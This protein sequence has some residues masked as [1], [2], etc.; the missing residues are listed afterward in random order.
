MCGRVRAESCVASW[1]RRRMYKGNAR[2]QT[3]GRQ[4]GLVS[5]QRREL[6]SSCAAGA[7][8][9]L[10]RAGCAIASS[11][12]A[13][14]NPI[15]S[16]SNREHISGSAPRLLAGTTDTWNKAQGCL[17]Y[18]SCPRT[19]NWVGDH[20]MPPGPCRGALLPDAM[21]SS[22]TQ[23]FNDSAHLHRSPKVRESK[24]LRW[25]CGPLHMEV[26]KSTTRGGRKRNNFRSAT[27]AN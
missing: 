24:W 3:R 27:N 22:R 10:L 15:H 13:G 19:T 12:K 25:A 8:L 26:A 6:R 5:A 2:T 7:A 11:S 16:D 23:P 17:A 14:A 20:K 21:R 1:P 18:R 9:P 4:H